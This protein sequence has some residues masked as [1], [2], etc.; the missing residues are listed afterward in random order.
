[1]IAAVEVKGLFFNPW[2]QQITFVHPG[3]IDLNANLLTFTAPPT[4]SWPWKS[5]TDG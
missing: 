5:L 1:M 4:Y 3:R 2:G